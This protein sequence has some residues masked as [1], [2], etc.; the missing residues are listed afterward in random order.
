MCRLSLT[1]YSSIL[2]AAFSGCQ[3]APPIRTTGTTDWADEVQQVA[4]FNQNESPVEKRAPGPAD[5]VSNVSYEEELHLAI[6]APK[7][8]NLDEPVSLT[9][10]DFEGIAFQNNPTLSAAAA[11]IQAAS[12]KQIQAGLYP[13]PV[14]GYHANEVGNFGTAGGQGGFVRQKFITGGKLQLDQ[15]IAG[16]EVDEAHFRWHAQEQRV[17]SDV[18]IRFYETLVAQ[19]KVKLTEELV[20]IGDNLVKSTQTLLT[21][22]QAT[23]N[24]LLQAEIRADNARILYDNAQ[25]ESLE[26]WRR[27]AAVVGVPN[28]ERSP[29]AGDLDEN[30]PNFDWDTS[31]T[32]VLTNHPELNAAKARVDQFSFAV[33]RARK[34]PLPDIDVFVSVRHHNVSSDEVANIQVGIP[35]PIFNRNQGNIQSAQSQWMAATNNVERIE[36]D[37]QDRFAVTFRRYANAQQQVTRYSKRILPK[38]Q[39]SLDLVTVGFKKGQVEYLTLLT[40]QQTFVEVSLAHLD[41]AREL[42]VAAVM[43]DGQLLTNS[44]AETK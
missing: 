38:A 42:R 8:G 35:L 9:L 3:S 30:L 5:Y 23:E 16:K 20:Q 19:H 34:E 4:E 36:L 11:R 44:L 32:Q 39:R 14:I 24:D 6:N 21:N 26:T 33:A 29:L 13:N 31:F 41:A 28:I 37:L 40:S 18:R 22:R 1:I 15:A 12:G 43:I 10:A 25:N 2:L 17:L 27:L 7:E